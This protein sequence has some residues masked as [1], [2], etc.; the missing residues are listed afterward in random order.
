MPTCN[1]QAGHSPNQQ[2]QTQPFMSNHTPNLSA[3]HPTNCQGSLPNSSGALFVSTTTPPRITA[4][5]PELNL[6]ASMRWPSVRRSVSSTTATR[7]SSRH[8]EAVDARSSRGIRPMSGSMDSNTAQ[9]SH[10]I[11]PQR[12][13]SRERVHA[14]AI[15]T[16]QPHV[17]GAPTGETTAAPP[18]IVGLFEQDRSF[19]VQSL[20]TTTMCTPREEPTPVQPP[21]DQYEMEAEAMSIKDLRQAVEDL[22][23][24]NRV[25]KTGIMRARDS[26]AAL[27]EGMNETYMLVEQRQESITNGIMRK[28]DAAKRQKAKL[29]THLSAVERQ[30]LIEEARLQQMQRNIATLSQHLMQEEKAIESRMRQQLLQ[31]NSQRQQLEERLLGQPSSLLQLEDL[32]DEAQ[33][34]ACHYTTALFHPPPLHSEVMSRQDSSVSE[35]E[36]T[37]WNEGSDANQIPCDGARQSRGDRPERTVVEST[38]NPHEVLHYLER[39][40]AV[41][42]GLRKEAMETVD[43]YASTSK[44]LEKHVQL[45]QHK[46]HDQLDNNFVVQKQREPGKP[47]KDFTGIHGM[48]IDSEWRLNCQTHPDDSLTPYTTSS[49]NDSLLEGASNRICVQGQH[50]ALGYNSA[51]SKVQVSAATCVDS[52]RSPNQRQAL[53]PPMQ[54]LPINNVVDVLPV[55]GM[56]KS[57]PD[58]HLLANKATDLEVTATAN[59]SDITLDPHTNQYIISSHMGSAKESSAQPASISTTD[60][61][62]RLEMNAN[63]YPLTDVT[64]DT[65]M[66]GSIQPAVGK[67][68][69]KN[70]LSAVLDTALPTSVVHH[71]TVMHT[72]TICVQNTARMSPPRPLI[73]EATTLKYGQKCLSNES[74]PTSMPLN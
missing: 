25:S 6:T 23:T 46:L 54:D 38:H 69:S 41:V 30:K 72:P 63:Q 32:V 52:S 16:Y 9:S 21:L 51:A 53:S 61:N 27:R 37:S 65:L 35:P 29:A 28:L 42:E 19:T 14:A 71:G 3:I 10:R 39:E 59:L 57:S 4:N 1:T 45:E 66:P 58:P 43:R 56:N 64:G 49:N 20:P 47:S 18:L 74:T 33:K 11:I 8:S 48:E 24:G 62:A 73:L 34:L 67:R 44:R 17:V 26:Y 12:G 60:H 55:S 5:L 68:D 13:T 36:L 15:H 2:Q 7:E 50:Y 22:H 31:L 70:N 40:I